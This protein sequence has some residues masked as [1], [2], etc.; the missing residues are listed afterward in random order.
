MS[1]SANPIAWWLD[2]WGPPKLILLLCSPTLPGLV[3]F[4]FSFPLDRHIP[5]TTSWT[6]VDVFSIWWVLVA[7]LFTIGAIV[8][9]LSKKYRRKQT[10]FGIFVGAMAIAV[11]V[12][13]NLLLAVAM[14][15]AVYF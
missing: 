8:L 13:L 1:R 15:G 11:T 2:R 3:L 9:F 14:W 12:I 10:S 5:L 7:H 6:Y 4:I